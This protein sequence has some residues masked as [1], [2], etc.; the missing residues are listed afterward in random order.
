M[1][2]SLHSTRNLLSAQQL[3]LHWRTRVRLWLMLCESR[4]CK[5]S[6]LPSRWLA[7]RVFRQGQC[8]SFKMLGTLGF[9]ARRE[10]LCDWLSSQRL[11]SMELY[12]N[13]NVNRWS[14]VTSYILNVSPVFLLA[15]SLTPKTDAVRSSETSDHRDT[16]QKAAFTITIVGIVS[17]TEFWNISP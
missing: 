8:I 17:L 9:R 2:P 7:A 13:Y 5:Y 10:L 1:A 14:G 11:R 12:L 6:W 16:S 15:Y 3:R 4:Q